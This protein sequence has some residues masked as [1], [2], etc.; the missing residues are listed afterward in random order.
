VRRAAWPLTVRAQQSAMPVILT[1]MTGI[2]RELLVKRQELL[3]R[4]PSGAMLEFAYLGESD[5]SMV[6]WISVSTS[7]VPALG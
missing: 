7:S 3:L 6:Y 4:S 1:G 2:S 5:P